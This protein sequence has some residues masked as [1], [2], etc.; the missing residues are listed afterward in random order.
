MQYNYSLSENKSRRITYMCL[1]QTD[2]DTAFPQSKPRHIRPLAQTVKC[3]KGYTYVYPLLFQY[4]R[5]HNM[6]AG[7]GQ[8]NM[9]PFDHQAPG[10][11]FRPAI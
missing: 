6:P 9:N 1:Q 7:V 5:R 11:L 8:T 10:R 3:K 4:C 2:I